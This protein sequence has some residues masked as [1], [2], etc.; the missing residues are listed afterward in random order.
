MKK[1]IKRII[2]EIDVGAPSKHKKNKQKNWIIE[3][4]W[5]S[6]KD[7]EKYPKGWISIREYTEDWTPEAWNSKFKTS[8]GAR[9]H[10]LSQLRTDYFLPY[11]QGREWRTRNIISGEI[12]N[13]DNI[14]N[15]YK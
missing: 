11:L 12:I 9:D 1:Y 6:R 10:I 8:S 2:R 14:L 15:Y 13:F 5:L 4:I 3:Y 7:F